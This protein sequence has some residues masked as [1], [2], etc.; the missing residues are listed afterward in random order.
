MSVNASL[1]DVYRHPT[2]L[3]RR[4]ILKILGADF[5]I[6]D[7]TGSVAL[8]SRMKAFKLREDIR[9]YAGEDMSQE[10][11]TIKARQILDFSA[12]YDV[13]DT[14][15]RSKVGSVKRKGWRSLLRDEWILMDAHDREIGRVI[16]DS[17]ALALVRRFLTNLVPQRYSV[18]VDGAVVAHFRQNVNPFVIKLNLD[19]APDVADRL[20]RRL[21]LAAAILLCAVEGKQG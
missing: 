10:L 3:I 12:A 2:Y 18:E 15:S 11:L 1:A 19:F 20:D 4:K 14:P 21:G 17:T 6:F 13:V 5:H 7:S 9:L 8:F 16:E